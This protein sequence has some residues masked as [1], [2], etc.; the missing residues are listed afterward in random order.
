MDTSHPRVTDPF[1]IFFFLLGD[2]I[3]Q[4]GSK[5]STPGNTKSIISIT[6]F[7]DPV[8][9]LAFCI[10][11]SLQKLG[12]N[13]TF[14]SLILFFIFF[15]PVFPVAPQVTRSAMWEPCGDLMGL[16]LGGGEQDQAC[17]GVQILGGGGWGST[18]QCVW[19]GEGAWAKGSLF[20]SSSCLCVYA[21]V[22]AR[23]VVCDLEGTP[24]LSGRP[25][26]P[27]LPS[28]SGP[29]GQGTRGHAEGQRHTPRPDPLRCPPR[30]YQTPIS[31]FSV[32]FLWEPFTRDLHPCALV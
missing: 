28:P 14:F 23:V 9:D 20:P 2:P 26:R 21:C 4:P 27:R 31:K 10:I 7:A 25:L 22:H 3:K 5:V 18:P 15:T 30:N 17:D 1:L 32:L 12:N 19:E 24:P 11:G 29:R 8:F 16:G 6:C 13:R